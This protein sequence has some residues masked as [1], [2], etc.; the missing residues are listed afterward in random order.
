MLL[1]VE[2][3]VMLLLEV[4]ML[5]EPVFKVRVG[6]IREPVDWVMEPLPVA[7]R[8]T[9]VVP[10]T[11]ASRM[12]ESL[13]PEPATVMVLPLRAPATVVV[14]ALLLLVKVKLL[15]VEAFKVIAAAE[16]V[17]DT[18]PLVLALKVEAAVET[19]NVVGEPARLNEVV[20]AVLSTL[21]VP[22]VLAVM[23]EVVAPVFTY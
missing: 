1:V 6:V 15:T 17:T 14:P 9:E 7:V 22:V 18:V 20:L 12:M 2:P 11:P 5:P 4:P 23:L 19:F 21:A 3:V 10:V 13:V 16:S 8:V